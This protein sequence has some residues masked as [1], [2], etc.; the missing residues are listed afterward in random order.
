MNYFF[1]KNY[2]GNFP[3]GGE[4]NEAHLTDFFTTSGICSFFHLLGIIQFIVKHVCLVEN[5][6]PNA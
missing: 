4:A 5:F 3:H 2:D 6:I 1:E